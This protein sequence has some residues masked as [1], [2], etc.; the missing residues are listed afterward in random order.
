MHGG[1]CQ[2]CTSALESV[3][4]I[5]RIVRGFNARIQ[6]SLVLRLPRQALRADRQPDCRKTAPISSGLTLP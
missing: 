2:A 6:G 1:P 5:V 4:T 3:G